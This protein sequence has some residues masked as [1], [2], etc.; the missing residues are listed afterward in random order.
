MIF[1]TDV[2]ISVMHAHVGAMLM[3]LVWPRHG[4]VLPL[5]LNANES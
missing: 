3:G 5:A 4:R 2:L 1:Q